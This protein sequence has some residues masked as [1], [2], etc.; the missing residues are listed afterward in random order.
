MLIYA[1]LV[2]LLVGFLRGGRL[3]GLAE[4]PL[5]AV[6][7]IFLS[8]GIQ[9]AL[10]LPV[11]SSLV[12]LEDWAGKLH[13]LSYLLLF[14]A[15]VVNWRLPGMPWMG[16]GAALNFTVIA[17]N[18]MRMPVAEAPLRGVGL[19]RLADAL[20][21][22]TVLTHRLLTAETR[23]ALLADVFPLPPPFP[24]PAVFSLGDVALMVGA[25]ILV[26]RL[27]LARGRPAAGRG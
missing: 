12:P 6:P 20:V 27:M 24:R 2:S 17:F 3:S 25:F 9:L 23:L 15:F 21:A 5:R 13:L 10:H 11:A 4:A 18:G 8:F 7:L 22:D 14:S 16:F 1:V 26:Q 19:D